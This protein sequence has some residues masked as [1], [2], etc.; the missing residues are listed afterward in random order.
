[1]WTQFRDNA[2]PL[3]L[4][5]IVAHDPTYRPPDADA[6]L[7][8]REWFERYLKP[9]SETDLISEHIRHESS[10]VSGIGKVEIS[11]CDRPEGEFDRGSWDFR[12][13]FSNAQP[14]PHDNY[15]D[16]SVADVVI[17]CGGRE[18]GFMG[19]GEM[20]APNE[21][22]WWSKLRVEP[23]FRDA[24]ILVVGDDP[25]VIDRLLYVAQT[26]AAEITWITSREADPSTNTALPPMTDDPLLERQR[27]MNAVRELVANARIRWV[28]GA[29][30][31]KTQENYDSTTSP[32][33]QSVWPPALGPQRVIVEFS[34]ALEG[35]RE[36]NV[37]YSH[38]SQRPNWELTR[39]L[40]LDIC[41]ITDAPRPFSQYLLER[42]S[43]YSVEYPAPDPSA[44]ITS[45]PNYYVLG[46]KSFGRMPGFLFQH[47]L[48]QIRDVFT[49]IGDRADLD[50]YA[51]M[52]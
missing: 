46:S 21:L 4:A 11:K 48:R 42:P 38:T 36:Y 32:L 40:Q 19:H 12:L 3:G 49:I 33:P 18:S 28:P 34:G 14:N 20:R 5:A 31:E 35:A 27:Q 52:K 1:M 6:H 43:P 41:P 22:K 50:L 13:L 47:G 25:S 39:E 37:I 24:S 15:E 45:E 29:W 44:L 51:Q 2:S 9:L 23:N 8:Y 26:E 10:E 30:I 16:I 7:T 17:D